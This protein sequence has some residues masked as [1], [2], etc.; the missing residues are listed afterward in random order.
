M[1]RAFLLLVKV[2]LLLCGCDGGI[3]YPLV[4]NDTDDKNQGKDSSSIAETDSFN[5]STDSTISTDSS[6]D[7]ST[8]FSTDSELL[9]CT[10]PYTCNPPSHCERFGNQLGVGA[11]PESSDVCCNAP[12]RCASPE[13]CVFP[14]T[15]E[16]ALGWLVSHSCMTGMICCSPDSYG[17]EECR[18]IEND[19]LRSTE[20]CLQFGGT[21]HSPKCKDR[22]YVCCYFGPVW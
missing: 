13:E 20:D 12:P 17:K 16:C 22:D 8:D 6:I 2:Q 11:C 15:G 5:F 14:N 18:G 7:V 9:L 3:L 19:C 1:I 10:L 21:P 4:K